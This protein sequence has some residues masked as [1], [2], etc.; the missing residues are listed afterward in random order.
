MV[1]AFQTDHERCNVENSVKRDRADAG[2][3]VGQAVSLPRERQ[4]ELGLGWWGG[5]QRTVVTVES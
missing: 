1:F 5:G 4:Q 2:R 3:P